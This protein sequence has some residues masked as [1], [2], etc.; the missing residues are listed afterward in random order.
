MLTPSSLA[1]LAHI[2]TINLT[3]GCAHECRYCYA[4][5][6]LTYP[7]NGKIRL[8]TNTLTKLKEELARKRR[9]PTVVY[10]SP[11]SDP[12][13]PVPEVL[14]MTY[15]VFR[16]L[17]ESNIGVAFVTKGQIP[18]QHHELLA[19]HTPLIQGRIGLITLDSSIAAAFEPGAAKPE[20]RLVQ[21]AGLIGAGIPVE[22]RLDP[23]LPGVTDGPD[24]LNRVCDALARIGVC[25]IAASVLFLRPAVVASLRRNIQD[26]SILQR[27]L[28]RFA[29]AAPLAIHAEN[30]RVRA[31]STADRVEIMERLRNIAAA[32]G[33]KVLVCAC[34]NPDITSGSCH[35]SGRWPPG[36]N[37]KTVN[38]KSQLLLF[39]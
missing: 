27:L 15:E 19:A 11:S 38:E 18:Q 6:Y 36:D 13:Q 25:T 32:N 23:I 37:E 22:A 29:N 24:C 28:D 5:G 33:L 3:T 17:L 30:S 31:I 14:D 35:I 1:C 9:K 4:Q 26:K 2:P 7:G 8:Y 20:T 16:F 12:F 39:Q 10:F 34:K 21:A